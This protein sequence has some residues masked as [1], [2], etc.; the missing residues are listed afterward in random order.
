MTSTQISMVSAKNFFLCTLVAIFLSADIGHSGEGENA[1]WPQWRGP[2]RDGHSSEKGLLKSWSQK[3]P[4]ILWEIS[5]GEGFSGVSVSDNRLF[6]MWDS[7]ESQLL[8]CL[9]ALSGQELWDYRVGESFKDGF[10]NG[11]RSTPT[12][13]G[14]NV[15]AISAGGALHAV[16][17]KTGKMLWSRDLGAEYDSQIPEHGYSSSPLVEGEKLI[18]EVG[19]NKDYAFVA[20]NK[21]TGDV[22]WHSQTDQAAYSSPISV[23]I[24]GTR[25]II[26]LSASGLYAVSPDDGHLFWHHRW[27]QL[28][29]STGIPTNTMTPVFIPPDK[30]F[31]SNGY[32]TTTGAVVVKVVKTDTKFVPETVWETD[33]M[34]NLINSSVLVG[35]HIYGF[36]GSILKSFDASSGQEKWK[37]RGFER[38]SLIAADGF[39]IVLGERGKL[40]LVEATSEAYR[41]ISEL[42]ILGNKC[43]TSPSL[44]DGKLYVRDEQ[45]MVCL[46][47]SA[48]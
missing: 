22:L 14:T 33:Q 45:K 27:E 47:I 7:G 36:D 32:G 24:H 8:V 43:W 23:N 28:C 1:G 44:S 10:G 25:Q 39:L 34:K 42:Q 31:I 48:K 17:T 15:Y 30:V 35:D 3:Q 16:D 4:E 13:D 5:A 29:P 38:G 37:T 20:F 46:N 40:A 11:P 26:F 12:V 19:G 6:T 21:K 2:G 18:V 9:D 41:E